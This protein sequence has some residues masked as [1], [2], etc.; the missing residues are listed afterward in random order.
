MTTEIKET[1][2]KLNDTEWEVFKELFWDSAANG[3]DFGVL[4]CVVPS[5]RLRDLGLNRNQIGGYITDLE[6]KGL[7]YVWGTELINDV[8]PCTQYELTWKEEILDRE[9]AERE[10]QELRV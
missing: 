3:H 7:V 10:I 9:T 6:K 1:I 4:E 8:E 5:P 2:T